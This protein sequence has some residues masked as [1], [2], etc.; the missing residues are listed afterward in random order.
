[1]Y[2]VVGGKPMNKI[3]DYRKKAKVSQAK[4][5]RL[6]GITP[7]TIGNYES[8]IRNINLDMCWRI[9]KAINQLGVNCSIEDL[10]PDPKANSQ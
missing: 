2:L 1:V 6:I 5:A 10:F 3:A 7:S 8:G 4:L 9:V